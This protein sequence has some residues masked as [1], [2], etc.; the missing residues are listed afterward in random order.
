M[1]DCNGQNSTFRHGFTGIGRQVH[2][3][4]FHLALVCTHQTNILCGLNADL[5]FRT[6]QAI[7]HAANALQHRGQIQ[8]LKRHHLLAPKGKKLPC[9]GGR[10]F[11]CRDNFFGADAFRR[12]G[13]AGF[14][15]LC[16]ATD[17]AENIVEIVGYPARQ[18]AYR[19]L[20][21]LFETTTKRHSTRVAMRIERD[22]RNEQYTYADLREL[23]T[24]AAAFF[25]AHEIKSGDRAILFSHNAPEWGMTYF[26]VLKAGASCI[27]V[28]AESST[29]EIINFA[30]AGD[31]SAI[32]ISSKLREEHSDLNEKLKSA[33][34]ENVRIWTFDEVFELPAQA[35]EDEH[36]ARLP[37][38]ILHRSSGC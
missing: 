28:D 5:H 25:A 21:E 34:L 19:D 35:V 18:T 9:K 17:N 1:I 16:V 31:A 27:P 23:A 11:R 24:R 29:S 15:K 38:R 32:V 37:Q 3:D 33:G 8:Q 20:V 4:L 7:H 6:D 13:R 2:D 30:K 12:A 22:G 14:K 36:I 10:F 26:G